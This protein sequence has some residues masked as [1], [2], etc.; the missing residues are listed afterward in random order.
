MTDAGGK[1]G[2]V[3]PREP[4]SGG[5][6]SRGSGQRTGCSEKSGAWA[7]GGLDLSFSVG[8]EHNAN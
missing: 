8:G 3:L 7:G 5:V 1:L 2:C 6:C 4:K